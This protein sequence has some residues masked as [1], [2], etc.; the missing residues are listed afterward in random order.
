MKKSK[1][2]LITVLISCNMLKILRIM[3]L[4]IFLLFF[5]VL[6]IF[7]R[8]SYSQNTKLTLNLGE[9]TIEEVLNAIEKQS[10]FYF[11]VNQKLVNINRKVNLQVTE[12][13]ID[14]ILAQVFNGT[15]V[16]YI[17]IDRQ[18]ILSPSEYL[19]E[20]K[21]LLQPRTVSGKV[22]DENGNPLPGLNVT[23]KGTTQ[24]TVTNRDGE[25][26]IQVDDKS[27]VLVFSYVGYIT[28]E[29]MVG[30]QPTLYLTMAPDYI[31]IDEVVAVGYG[32]MR[33]Y[34]LTG[35]V[36]SVRSDDIIKSEQTSLEQSIRGRVAGVQVT[37]QNYTPGGGVA[38]R[39]RGGNSIAAGNEPLY[40]I[41][42][43]PVSNVR[44]PSVTY[45]NEKQPL[46]QG[47]FST[48]NPNE[49]ESIEILK[50]ASAT[51][52]YGSRASNGV[53]LI[54][55]KRGE[56]G[57]TNVEL[58]GYY[59]FSK[60][61]KKLNLMDGELYKTVVNEALTNDGFAPYV[62]T[63]PWSSYNTD[64]EDELY[65]ETGITQNTQLSVRGGNNATKFAIIGSYYKQSSITV[66]KG[67]FKR[68]TFRVNLDH[69]ISKKLAIGNSLV[70][71]NTFN[72]VQD[73][74]GADI[75]T[76]PIHPV[77]DANGNYVP[78]DDN[79]FYTDA[80]G[81]TNPVG[82]MKGRRINN[83]DIKGLG[84]VYLNWD[85]TKNLRFKTSW[86]IDYND[87][88]ADL[89]LPKSISWVGYA[90]SNIDLSKTINWLT[91]NTLTYTKTWNA[92]HDI[93]GMVGFT[94]QSEQ[95]LYWGLK[96][97]EFDLSDQLGSNN[98]EESNIQNVYSEK[99]KWD[100]L[101]FIG[102]INYAYKDKYLV[103]GS[104]RAD[105]S[106]KFGANNKWGYFPS[107]AVAWRLSEEPFMQNVGAFDN[108]KIRMSYGFTGNQNI[109]PYTSLAAVT[110]GQAPLNGTMLVTAI[111]GA[112]PYKDLKW[113]KT[114][115]F[116]AG[117]DAAFLHSRISF[118][119]D[120]Y[121]KNTKDLLLNFPIPYTAGSGNFLLRNLGSLQNKGVEFNF[122]SYNL[123][124]AF[125]WY[126]NLNL[127]AN[128][129]KVTDLAGIKD[130]FVGAEIAQSGNYEKL[131]EGQP[132]GNFFGFETDGI[133]QIGDNILIPGEE[134]G[135]IKYVD[136]NGDNLITADDRVMLG[137]ALPK[138]TWGMTN[139]FSFKNFELSV[140]IY[141]IH[142][143]KIFNISSIQGEE[144]TSGHN[145][146]EVAGINRWT[147]SNP[148][149]EYAKPSTAT[150]NG[151]FLSDRYLEDGSFVRIKT[152][153]LAYNFPV[154]NISWLNKASVY[155]S[156]DNLALFTDYTGYDPE[157]NT[158]GTDTDL[159]MGI[160]NLAVPSTRT[161]IFG[162]N[163]SF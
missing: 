140:F 114:A 52:I 8:G 128:R 91:E 90:T 16:D 138:M 115:Q 100:L 77:V 150:N 130:Y 70:I 19:T 30:D 75:W 28:Q 162:F 120:Y 49:I 83:R 57:K 113:E 152:V 33:K 147:P 105:G 69:Q 124:G 156:A 84:S 146:Y 111:P 139:D 112:P 86:G 161:F 85:I 13:K 25:Y 44:P 99:T 102:R 55:T 133:Y 159:N 144:L 131:S 53:I 47:V 76:L 42:G 31:G 117:V 20:A 109:P 122:N 37:Q 154:S 45:E 11:L 97:Q 39:I 129:N 40:V 2:S 98:I 63:E 149:N 3:K 96:G 68:G 71:S 134:P 135:N 43:F 103:T 64:W 119:A 6:Q 24:G 59:G 66:D 88:S 92:V 74:R 145:S 34:D 50:D 21:S 29:I 94:R 10:D 148:S 123:T 118:E 5:T 22:T 80:R 51:A 141:G 14:N 60:R 1:D 108:L 18:I 116:D 4:T 15:N 107:G 89:Y 9:T 67:E 35:S 32:T 12:Q 158:L 136:Q 65:G 58:S 54:T 48:I 41:D 126:T 142:G 121:I 82:F 157:I 151:K 143:N 62:W 73:Q 155:I 137:N 72:N 132:V 38:V 160:D 125:K 79:P 7:A 93:T 46:Q 78:L 110:T 81:V 87:L 36:A 106:S 17:I 27:I 163:V 104:I 56:A 61:A 26:T 127:S 95:Y 101:S 23:I 153:R